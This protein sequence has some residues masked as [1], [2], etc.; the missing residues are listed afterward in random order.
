MLSE[1]GADRSQ[2]GEDSRNEDGT[3]TTD[4]IVDRVRDPGAEKGDG[5]VRAG[6]DETDNP[7][8]LPTQGC[9]LS[10]CITETSRTIGDAE[11]LGKGQ[12]RTVG[13]GLVPALDSRGDGI[14][15]D[16]NV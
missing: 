8:V 2:D 3:T 14:E 4:V 1:T 12:V 6:I 15:N 10:A 13:A 9:V 11:L 7:A 5:N 16:G